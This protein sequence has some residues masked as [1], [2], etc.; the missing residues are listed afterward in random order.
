MTIRTTGK[1]LP[2]TDRVAPDLLGKLLTRTR[3]YKAGLMPS[4]KL[5]IS[6]FVTATARKNIQRYWHLIEEAEQ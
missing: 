2:K 1:T 5:V 6:W 4:G 3:V